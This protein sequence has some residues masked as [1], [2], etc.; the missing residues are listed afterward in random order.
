MFEASLSSL[1]LLVQS[2]KHD[3]PRAKWR[4]DTAMQMQMPMWSTSRFRSC[5]G[6]CRKYDVEVDITKLHPDLSRRASVPFV[7]I[8]KLC[9]EVQH[10]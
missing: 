9:I 4:V 5:R 1:R 6:C 7:Y 2:S 10:C 8:E 3:Q